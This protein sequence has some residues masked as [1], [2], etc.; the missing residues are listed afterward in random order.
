MIMMIVLTRRFQYMCKTHILN[1]IFIKL[2]KFVKFA[3]NVAPAAN[4]ES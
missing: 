4:A 2:D 1:T 3:P